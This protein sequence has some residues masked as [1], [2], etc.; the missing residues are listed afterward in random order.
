M[1]Q[2]KKDNTTAVSNQLE[3]LGVI[4]EL[5]PLP[6]PTHYS[7]KLTLKEAYGLFS[8]Y[9]EK[10]ERELI[11][12]IKLQIPLVSFEESNNEGINAIKMSMAEHL[13]T[14]ANHLESE[15]DAGNQ[16]HTKFSFDKRNYPN[17]PHL[18]T[19]IHAAYENGY[20][21]KLKA[22]P[23]NEK[24]N[25]SE[26]EISAL[27]STALYKA[28][29]SPP[30]VSIAAIQDEF[31]LKYRT[32]LETSLQKQP[33]SNPSDVRY[34]QLLQKATAD[35]TEAFSTEPKKDLTDQEKRSV[36][37][38]V[39]TAYIYN[40]FST[41]GSRDN[42][43]DDSF[44][45]LVSLSPLEPA[46]DSFK[47]PYDLKLEDIT[48]KAEGMSHYFANKIPSDLNFKNKDEEIDFL[49]AREGK[50]LLEAL[51]A[52]PRAPSSILNDHSAT[53]LRS[54]IKMASWAAAAPEGTAFS[55]DPTKAILEKMS[56]R[57]QSDK[58]HGYVQS[59]TYYHSIART[60]IN[61]ER[62]KSASQFKS[63]TPH[64]E[65]SESREINNKIKSAMSI[66]FPV[67]TKP[68]NHNSPVEKTSLQ[69]NEETEEEKSALRNLIDTTQNIRKE[70]PPP[71]T[72]EQ[73]QAIQ[74]KHEESVTQRKN[75]IA[76]YKK[77]PP[78]KIESPSPIMKDPMTT[79]LQHKINARP[80]IGTT[81]KA[82]SNPISKYDKLMAATR[83]LH[84]QRSEKIRKLSQLE[85]SA[86][87]ASRERDAAFNAHER[88]LDS[89]KSKDPFKKLLT[90][91]SFNNTAIKNEIARYESIRENLMTDEMR[92]DKAI[93]V[94]KKEIS[95]L[96]ADLSK[97]TRDFHE[98][99]KSSAKNNDTTNT[100]PEANHS[101]SLNTPLSPPKDSFPDPTQNN[102][103]LPK[104]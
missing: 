31:L 104:K 17:A 86:R 68:L 36:Q 75:E 92:I 73:K 53:R 14:Y 5:P 88:T 25:D 9:R 78:E 4:F 16:Y 24:N 65:A 42:E 57:I 64:E 34:N 7:P 15:I 79:P 90:F 70:I 62:E 82:S 18:T 30:E 20:R 35:F 39:D 38:T 100:H 29:P 74:I 69:A 46:P 19:Q 95:W 59:E 80:S 28:P 3:K 45:P 91:V 50:I 37:D 33:P 101:Q 48:K 41:K 60:A 54:A 56:W 77:R 44:T 96:E 67:D 10:I 12:A 43:L 103:N 51:N 76:D 83:N 87:Y 40:Q 102:V 1:P 61:I 26:G 55:T 85:D 11:E 13:Q 52:L 94:T 27:V 21:E 2:E 99:E 23:E 93:E 81:E 71:L 58:Q 8:Q 84:A 98:S 6:E 72:P 63:K 22:I 66:N 32:Y 49:K 97:A 47:T 89:L